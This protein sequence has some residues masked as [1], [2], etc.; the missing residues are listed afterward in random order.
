MGAWT[1]LTVDTVVNDSPTDIGTLYRS[2]VDSNPSKANRL[3][4][5]VAETVAIFL[6]AVAANPACEVDPNPDVVPTTGFR[7]ALNYVI[8][9]L[10]MEMGVQFAPEAYT[11]TTRADVWLRMVESGTINPVE[12]VGVD[13]SP[14]YSSGM[15]AET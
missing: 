15:R 4:E 11:L 9:N 7:H 5:I 3:R 13:A 1:E 2:W 14:S 10:G 8:F 12:L 6:E